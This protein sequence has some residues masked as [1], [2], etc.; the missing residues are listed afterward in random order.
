MTSSSENPSGAEPDVF[1]CSRHGELDLT[2]VRVLMFGEVTCATCDEIVD[3]RPE[4]ASR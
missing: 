2:R 3:V 1:T 4:W